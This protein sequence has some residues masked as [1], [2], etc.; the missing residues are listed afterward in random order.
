[1]ARRRDYAAEYRRRI[2]RGLARGETRQQARGHKPPA[3]KSE[4][5]QRVERYLERHPG[6]SR[7]QAAGKRSAASLPAALRQLARR[8][9]GQKVA[10]YVSFFG[11]DRQRDGSWRRASFTLGGDG[12]PER[13]FILGPNLH[14]PGGLDKLAGIADLIAELV[15]SGRVTLIGGKYLQAMVDY[16]ETKS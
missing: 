9:S 15:A 8:G 6:A 13:E 3:G 2:Q 12:E 1:M 11:L 16:V 10:P 7:E 4:Y 14:G 5:R